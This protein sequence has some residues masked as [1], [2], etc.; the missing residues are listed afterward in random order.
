MAGEEFLCI[1]PGATSE[2]EAEVCERI[3][4]AIEATAVRDRGQTISCTISLGFGS[5]PGTPAEDETDLIRMAD[6]ALY[7]AKNEGRNRTVEAA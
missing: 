2:G 4:N 1:L 7:R 6:E 5:Y 3:R